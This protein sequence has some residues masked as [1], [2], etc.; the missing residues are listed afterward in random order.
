MRRILWWWQKL[1]RG[2]SDRD[3]WNLDDTLAQWLLPRLKA[4]QK[5]TFGHPYGFESE[6]EWKAAIG[7]MIWAIERRWSHTLSVDEVARQE[8]GFELF[9][10]YWR[11]LWD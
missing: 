6:E 11:A 7:E 8:K 4:F 1:T 9:G 2:W 10:K 3:L 5:K